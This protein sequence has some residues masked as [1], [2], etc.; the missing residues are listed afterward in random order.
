MYEHC[1]VEI[2]QTQLLSSINVLGA[3]GWE[4]VQVGLPY[5]HIPTDENYT[6]YHVV[7]FKRKV[8]P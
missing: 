6:L 1:A 4:L 8:K 7:W 3:E 5:Q 2:I